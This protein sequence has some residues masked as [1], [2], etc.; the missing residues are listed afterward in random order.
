MTPLFAFLHH[1][2]T[3]ALVGALVAEFVL[4]REDLTVKNARNVLL[5]D[6]AFG[7]S[8]GTAVSVGLLRVVYFENGSFY[9]FHSVPFVAKVSLFFTVG[10]ISI[11]PTIEFLS[12]RKSVFTPLRKTHAQCAGSLFSGDRAREQEAR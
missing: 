9:Y 12:W 5:A 6:L 1:L 11:Y 8:A 3:F 2:A 10:L 4:I 7:A